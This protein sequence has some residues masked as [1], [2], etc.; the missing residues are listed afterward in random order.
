MFTSRVVA[1]NLV[2]VCDS[3]GWFI[4]Y[5]VDEFSRLTKGCVLKNKTA[6]SVVDG[7]LK[8]WIFGFG[9]CLGPPFS[10]FFS[11]FG[12]EFVNKELGY[13]CEANGISR[14]DTVEVDLGVGS[15]ILSSGT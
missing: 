1:L 5:C 4:L 7:I 11:D 8:V 14:A 6:K 15:P 12:L 10:H 9:V 3:S 2:D 13:L